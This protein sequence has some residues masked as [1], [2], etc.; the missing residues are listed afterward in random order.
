MKLKLDHDFY[1]LSFQM[2]SDIFSCSGAEDRHGYLWDRHYRILLNK[3]K[4]EDV[5][6]CVA[7]HPQDPETA[8]S[9]S[10]DNCVKIWRSR[11]RCREL[12]IDINGGSGTGS[13]G[14]LRNEVQTVLNDGEDGGDGDGVNMGGEQGDGQIDGEQEGNI[15]EQDGNIGEQNVQIGE[16]DG[17]I[18]EHLLGLIVDQVENV[19]EHDENI[20]EHVGVINELGADIGE[21][22]ALMDNQNAPIEDENAPIQEPSVPLNNIGAPD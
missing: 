12:G 14:V 7:F 10:D 4:H 16:H 3:F 6:N 8:V 17:N 21:Q 13:V 15:G 1:A 2:R 9:V 19:G 22:V 20:G 5:V 11:N 18:G